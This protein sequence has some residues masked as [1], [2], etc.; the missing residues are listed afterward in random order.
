MYGIEQSRY[1]PLERM[2]GGPRS[3]LSNA[4]PRPCCCISSCCMWLINCFK[5]LD[6]EHH[7]NR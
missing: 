6:Q 2:S 5:N 3:A 7:P 1:R 4:D